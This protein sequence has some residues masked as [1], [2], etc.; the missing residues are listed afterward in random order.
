MNF[1]SRSLAWCLCIATVVQLPLIVRAA[2]SATSIAKHRADVIVNDPANPKGMQLRRARRSDEA[3]PEYFRTVYLW[4]YSDEH[5]NHVFATLN[6]NGLKVQ[7]IGDVVFE[8]DDKW[9][10]VL[11]GSREMVEKMGTT[12][13][14]DAGGA[15][16]LQLK[17]VRTILLPDPDGQ[18]WIGL[19]AFERPAKA[20][21]SIMSSFALFGR[22]GGVH[23][24]LDEEQARHRFA[25]IRDINEAIERIYREEK[26]K[27]NR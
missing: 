20:R 16:G 26:S 6:Q 13:T 11:R 17:P 10:L 22:A 19:V 12:V 9:Y 15:S 7:F 23:A 8:T 5:Y 3:W 24:V 21:P 27:Q 18:A 1:G 4:P 25:V 2:E 14:L